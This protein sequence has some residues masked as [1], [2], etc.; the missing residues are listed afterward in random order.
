MVANVLKYGS[1]LG[2]NKNCA[3]L[4]LNCILKNLKRTISVLE[5]KRK[6][7]NNN[8]EWNK[9]LD[10]VYTSLSKIQ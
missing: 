6:Y 7:R 5:I 2:C 1:M 3:T 9:I 10:A 4:T 8:I